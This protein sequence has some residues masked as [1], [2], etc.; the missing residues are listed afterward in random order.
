MDRAQVE[1]LVK[2]VYAARVRG[3]ADGAGAA[4]PAG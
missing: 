4:A 2:K 1:Q 3:D